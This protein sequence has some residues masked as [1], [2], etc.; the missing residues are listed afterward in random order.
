MQGSKSK[1]RSEDLAEIQED[2]RQ[3]V[4]LAIP[5]AGVDDWPPSSGP[6]AS[7]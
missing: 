3:K 2:D 4:V 6:M 5:V 7:N 1:V